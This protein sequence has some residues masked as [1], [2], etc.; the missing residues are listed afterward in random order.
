MKPYIADQW[1][2]LLN[3]ALE[4]GFHFQLWGYKDICRPVG[5]SPGTASCHRLAHLSRW[6]CRRQT[7]THSLHDPTFLKKTFGRP[8]MTRPLSQTGRSRVSPPSSLLSSRRGFASATTLRCN[9]N[10]GLRPT[11]HIRAPGEK[12]VE[13]LGLAWNWEC[14][15]LYMGDWPLFNGKHEFCGKFELFPRPWLKMIADCHAMK[16]GL[17]AL[18]RPAAMVFASPNHSIVFGCCIWVESVHSIWLLYLHPSER[19]HN[20]RIPPFPLPLFQSRL[21]LQKIDGSVVHFAGKWEWMELLQGGGGGSVIL[22][23]I[24]S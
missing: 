4:C 14:Y 10:Q 12:P 17:G 3:F 8:L 15:I 20:C 24:F 16:S 7:R 1:R 5:F 2:L 9:S 13:L 21:K 19:Y 11:T 6:C 23:P 22:F 18:W